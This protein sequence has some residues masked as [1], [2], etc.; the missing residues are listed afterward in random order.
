[1]KLSD[2][3]DRFLPNEV[4]ANFRS[5]DDITAFVEGLGEVVFSASD[6]NFY[7][8]VITQSGFRVFGNG[9]VTRIE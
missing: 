1:M 7:R 2:Y 9:Y 4:S 8:S 5:I 6:N 3:E